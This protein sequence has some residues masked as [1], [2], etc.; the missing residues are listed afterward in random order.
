[1][2]R[3]PSPI[4]VL[5]PTEADCRDYMVSD[6][7]PLFLDSTE[8]TDAL[9]MPHPGR[10]DR[11]TLLHRLFPGGSLKIVAGKA[12]RNL[13]RHTCRI[14]L[15]DEADAIEASAEGDPISLAEKRTLSFP[16]R[17]IIVGST[18]LE[19]ATSHIGRLYAQSD[20][21]VFECPCP[22]CGAFAEIRWQAIEWP[23]GEPERAAWRC[24]GCGALVEESH[25]RG[26][27]GRGRWRAT[28]PEVRG[29]AGF[30]LSALISPLANA[31]WG[32]LA[33]EFLR[34]KD[35]TATLRVFVNT[36]LG[37]PWHE[38]CDEFDEAALAGRVEGFDIDH[39]P[40]EVLAV[41]IGADVQDDRIEAT[42]LGHGA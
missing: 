12:P 3:E 7:E 1:V 34:A 31:A 4:L 19:E 22:H 11:N 6:L 33:A 20:R 28:A 23:E 30:R 38:D 36:V 41:T 14:L 17:K 37:E 16:D 15:V 40:G 25:K 24:L 39:V 8:I 26:M 32:K 10:S 42:I 27:V 5:M 13:R 2:V 35:D 29:H 9:P 18:P 21:R